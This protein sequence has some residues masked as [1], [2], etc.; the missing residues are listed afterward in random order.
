MVGRQGSTTT[1]HYPRDCRTHTRTQARPG[2]SKPLK[3]QPVPLATTFGSWSAL[4]MATCPALHPKTGFQHTAPNK[5][6]QYK[7]DLCCSLMHS[8]MI[9]SR[10]PSS[11]KQEASGMI[12]L[13]GCTVS[14]S[15]AFL[16]NLSSPITDVSRGQTTGNYV[17]MST[18]SAG[19]ILCGNSFS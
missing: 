18:N 7:V 12:P 17:H 4:W 11:R 5:E 9:D 14:P 10:P 16:Y 8:T 1:D 13:V 15:L 6:S 2:N 3:L 19:T